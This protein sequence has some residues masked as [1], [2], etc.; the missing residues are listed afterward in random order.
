MHLDSQKLRNAIAITP[1]GPFVKAVYKQ[2]VRH[3]ILP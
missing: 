2:V 3:T 1:N